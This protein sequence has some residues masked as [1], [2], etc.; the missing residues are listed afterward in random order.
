MR[1]Q[2]KLEP[3]VLCLPDITDRFWL[4]QFINSW[5]DVPHM[6]GTRASGT[7][8][9]AAQ[10]LAVAASLPTDPTAR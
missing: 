6:L 9:C 5:N 2:L 8:R 3:M 4:M 1:T 7:G 10:C